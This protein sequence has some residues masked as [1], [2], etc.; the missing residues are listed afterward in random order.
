MDAKLSKSQDCLNSRSA[1]K[2]RVNIRTDLLHVRNARD[3]PDIANYEDLEAGELQKDK[4]EGRQYGT[5]GT[6]KSMDGGNYLTMTGKVLF[7]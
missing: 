4:Q 7:D 6:R 2:K 3:S 5:M 1:S